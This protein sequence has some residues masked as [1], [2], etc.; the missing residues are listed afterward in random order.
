MTAFTPGERAALDQDHALLVQALDRR[1]EI[2]RRD[3]EAGRD[4]IEAVAL[5]TYAFARGDR[6]VAAS[7]L[8]V[9]LVKMAGAGV[10]S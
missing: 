8:A 6:K 3:I 7:L 4:P 10:R 1:V 2:V 5:L 9:A